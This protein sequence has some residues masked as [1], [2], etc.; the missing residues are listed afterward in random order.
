MAATRKAWLQASSFILVALL[1]FALPLASWATASVT[2]DPTTN[3]FVLDES[4]T[5]EETVTVTV[6]AGVG[7]DKAD[8]YLLS[9]TTGSMGSPIAAVKAG[10]SDIVDGLIAEL[11]GVDLAFGV[12]DYKDFPYD[13]YAFKHSVSITTDTT[14]VKT[15]INAWSA[16]GGADGPE[17][18]LYA[19]DQLADSTIGW[20]PGAKKIIVWFGDA[21]GHDPVC[22]AIS[23][24]PYD[25]TEGSVTTKLVDA[26]ITVLAISTGTGYFLGLDDD[27]TVWAYDYTAACGTP[28][29]TSEQATRITGAT[30]GNHITGI[31]AGTIV[32]TIKDMVIEAVTTI[33]NLSLVPTGGTAGFVADISPASYGP[34]TLDDDHVLPFTVSWTGLAA[35]TEED[36]VFTGTLDVVADGAVMGHKPVKITVPSCTPTVKE[37]VVDIKPTSCPNPLNVN[38]GGVLPVAILGTASFDAAQVD[39][40]TVRL[41]GVEPLRWN[42]EDVAAPYTG[43][44]SDPPDR[45][46]CTTDGPDGILDLSLKFDSKDVVAALGPIEDGDVIVVQLTGQLIDGTEI[47]GEDVV[48][49]IK[50]ASGKG[51]GQ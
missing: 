11:P 25:I 42:L 12:G 49:I 46:D 26:D 44:I 47:V 14:A 40:S 6:P 39:A 1:I 3:D 2:I 18:Q 28:G 45:I 50:P 8:V 23:G 37:V 20:R 33:N 36:Q 24:L 31:N 32:Q 4:E 22:S 38:S 10:A 35:C 13:L 15:A 43:G 17:G 30:G 19:L 5:L 16:S 27:P 48:W 9:D 41:E 7:I 51:K 34:L 21:P 29:G